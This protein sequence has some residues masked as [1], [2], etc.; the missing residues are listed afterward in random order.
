MYYNQAE[1]KILFTDRE[2][3]LTEAANLAMDDLLMP[4]VDASKWD[5]E[6]PRFR[7]SVGFPKHTRGG[8]AVAVCFPTAA[9]TDGVNEIFINPEVDDPIRVLDCMIHELIHAIDN[10]ASGHRNFFAH[11]A[12]KVGLE[13]KLTA[14]HA[15]EKLATYLTEYAERLGVF[16][17]SR[18]RVNKVHK[19]SSTRQIKV[20]CTECG[21][22]FRSSATQIARIPG[23][24]QGEG[25]CPVCSAHSLDLA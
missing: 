19:K 5:Y 18:M 6:R 25:C 23:I 8:K 22:I 2:Q 14:T 11:V 12:R 1:P 20:N 15:G 21:F 7:I 4:I 17:H 10:C 3:W 13:G 16:P 9:S 24:L